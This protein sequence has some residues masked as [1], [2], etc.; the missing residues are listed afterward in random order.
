[1][2]FQVDLEIGGDSISDGETGAGEVARLMVGVA[3]DVL[4]GMLRHAHDAVVLRDS[5]RAEVGTVRLVPD[6]HPGDSVWVT[7]TLGALVR[8]EVNRVDRRYGDYWGVHTRDARTRQQFDMV[9]V[10]QHGHDPSGKPML[11][12]V[13]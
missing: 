4:K 12:R 8:A 3:A 11:G 1:M 5:N 13:R 7:T 6:W 9:I 2:R 10:D